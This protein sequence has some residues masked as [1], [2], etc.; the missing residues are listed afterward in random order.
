LLERLAALDVKVWVEGDRLR[1]S[2]PRGVLTDALRAELA[3]R[4]AELLRRLAAADDAPRVAR[5]AADEDVAPLSFSQQRLWFLDQ[6]RPRTSEYNIAGATRL[7]GALDQLALV[8]A[9]GEIVRRHASMRTVF[10]AVDGAPVQVVRRPSPLDLPVHDLTGVAEGDREAHARRL[11][12]AEA[13]RPFDLAQGPLY[14]ATLYRMGPREHLLILVIHH[15]VSDGWSAGIFIQELTTLYTAF[16]EG[17]PS[18]LPELSMQYVDFARWQRQWLRGD[19]LAR[20]LEYWTQ[21]LRGELPPL[22]LPTERPRPPIQTFT[23]AVFTMDLP[24]ALVE[25]LGTL[26]RREGVTLFMTLLAAFKAL[27][28]RYTGQDDLL[29]GTPIANRT[30]VETEGLIG[31]F[32]NTLVLRTDVSGDPTFRELLLRVREVAL[33]AYAHQD[34]PFEKLVE[35]LRPA[36]DMSRSPL[37]QVMFS[38]FNLPSQALELPGLTLHPVELQTGTART[39]LTL[40]AGEDAGGGLKLGF[41][42]NTDLFDEAA[43]AAMGRHF[44]TLLEHVVDAPA[45]RLLSIPILDDEERRRLVA[46]WNATATERHETV[47]VHELVARQAR[48][49]PDAVAAVCEG[50]RM[51][52]GS[53]V[54]RARELATH[55]R[56]LGVQPGVRVGLC[57]ERSLDMLVGLLGILEAGGAYVPLD[58]A[59]PPERL[60]FM[61]EDAACPVLVTQKHL[62]NVLP[63]AGARTVALDALGGP[64]GGESGQPEGRPATGDDLAYVI[65]TSGS[66]GRPKGVQISHRALVNLLES[67]ARTPGL[68]SG[69]VLLAVT[70]LSFDI[71]ALELYLPLVTGARVVVAKRDS[72]LDAARLMATLRDEGVTVMQATPSTWRLLRDAGWRGDRGFK[73]FCGGEALAAELAEALSAGGASVWN[74]YGPT[75][76]TIW[77]T[78]HQVR[79]GESPVPIGRPIANTRVYVLDARGEPVPVGVPGEL[80]IGGAGVAHG[81]L[82]RPEL[83]SDRFVPDVFTDD[84]GARLYRTGDRVRYRRDGALEFLDRLD[85]Q[86][87]VRGFRVELGEIESVLARHPALSLAVVTVRGDA[88]GSKRLAAYAVVKGSS[89]PSVDTLRAHLATKLP[90]YMIPSTFTILDALPLTPNGKIDRRRLPEPEIQRSA[91]STQFVSPRTEIERTVARVWREALDVPEVGAN[92]NFFDLGG[93]SLLIVQVHSKLGSLFDHDL[94][95]VEMFQYPTVRALA[96]RLGARTRGMAGSVR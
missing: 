14:R 63:T 78:V 95:V 23:G 25:A 24:P 5:T 84:P 7:V 77:S 13:A 45:T 54:A 93:H 58:P 21:H 87:K 15:I 94:S 69:D 6:L 85:N 30:R 2:A 68:A 83:T 51:T 62:L 89:T 61:I 71:A 1:C 88:S 11:L 46:D 36:R 80:Y 33:G 35:V 75:E 81:Y 56:P 70:T 9:L 32:A 18:P 26:S 4:K 31:F 42:Y 96:D 29:V 19:V 16:V 57:V 22:D 64:P 39:D 67:M 53:L 48:R 82:N 44:R 50:E 8:R 55:L 12:L 72:V 52:Y 28:A 40:Q 90:E 34:V 76:T 10:A 66:T 65:Y 3:A 73:I 74:L 27:L 20:G 79:P 59:F 60:S 41:E 86:V 38:L 92:D 43:I 49:T 47:C 91:L 37:F 17:K